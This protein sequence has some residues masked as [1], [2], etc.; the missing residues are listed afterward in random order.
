[1]SGAA[2]VTISSEA[3]VVA[4]GM[5]QL[6]VVGPGLFTANATGTG[7][8]AAL[9]LRVRADGSQQY[10][11]VAQFDP[12]RNQFV[13]RPVDFGPESD[14]L[15]LVLFGT[16]IRNVRS[17]DSVR[18]RI[19]GAN[20]V[21][22]EVLYA[23]A[24][25]SFV[26]LDQVNL[27]LPRSL[28]GSDIADINLAV[29]G[30]AANTVQISFRSSSPAAAVSAANDAG[31]AP[32]FSPASDAALPGSMRFTFAT[33]IVMPPVSLPEPLAEGGDRVGGQRKTGSPKR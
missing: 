29:D 23:G 30:K 6:A 21:E 22:A 3:G 17:P 12:A 33:T 25:G 14:Q 4:R 15:F 28:A 10:E 18:A 13:F 2:T 1:M 20:G 5:I 9:V 26:G 8:A 19:G 11:P 24:Q 32:Q 7:V 16:G 27:R 31:Q